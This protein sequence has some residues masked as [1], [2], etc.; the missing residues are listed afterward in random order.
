MLAA[1]GCSQDLCVNR[2]HEHFDLHVFQGSQDVPKAG[3]LVGWP[4]ASNSSGTANWVKNAYPSHESVSKMRTLM[5]K[6]D[7]E[8]RGVAGG[9]SQIRVPVGRQCVKNTDP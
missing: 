8:L 3:W 6:A 9:G 7:F 1:A 5:H 4:A 2:G